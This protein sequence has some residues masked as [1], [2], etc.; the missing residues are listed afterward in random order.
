MSLPDDIDA[1]F[2]KAEAALEGSKVRRLS[3]GWSRRQRSHKGGIYRGATFT[4]E[5]QKWVV[6]RGTQRPA[7]GRLLDATSCFMALEGAERAVAILDPS[8]GKEGGV[9]PPAPVRKRL[10][11]AAW[12]GLGALWKAGPEDRSEWDLGDELPKGDLGLAMD[13]F[14]EALVEAASPEWAAPRNSRAAEKHVRD[15]LQRHLTLHGFQR[16]GSTRFQTFWAGRETDGVWTRPGGHPRSVALEVKV[17]EDADAPF[18]QIVDD[19]GKFD[20]VI[21]V[22][23]ITQERTLKKLREVEALSGARVRLEQALPVKLIEV[24]F[25]ALCKASMTFG[26]SAYPHLVC[27]KCGAQAKARDGEVPR[28]DSISDAGENP[29]FIGRKKCWRRYRFGGYVTMYDPDNCR[30]LEAFY[31]K[32][33]PPPALGHERAECI[34]R[35]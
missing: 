19:L 16:G 21:Q 20:A 30:T 13:G 1:I 35:W 31:K 25:C 7:Y 17:N 34:E 9:M 24:R 6:C 11:Y 22:R 4:H 12:V 10:R 32:H 26:N 15:V 14:R 29:V 2:K 5:G 3:G 33:E 27:E 18:G 8:R 23:L 28:F